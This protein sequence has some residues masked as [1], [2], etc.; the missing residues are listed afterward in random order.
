M[1]NLR[2]VYY[3]ALVNKNLVNTHHQRHF[4][5]HHRLVI[6]IFLSQLMKI[7]TNTIHHFFHKTVALTKLQ[8]LTYSPIFPRYPTIHKNTM[9]RM[10]WRNHVPISMILLTADTNYTTKLKG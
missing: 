1:D 8:T 2:N 5:K 9:H 10:A 3:G 4:H 6:V 7:E